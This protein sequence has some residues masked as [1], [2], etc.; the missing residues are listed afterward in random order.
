[1][2]HSGRSK[3]RWSTSTPSHKSNDFNPLYITKTQTNP[4][5]EKLLGWSTYTS[6]DLKPSHCLLSR[7][8]N[9]TYDFATLH[10]SRNKHHNILFQCRVVWINYLASITGMAVNIQGSEQCHQFLFISTPVITRLRRLVSLSIP[11]IRTAT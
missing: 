2:L 8:F 4:A 11:P 10:G 6:S 7:T 9:R 5:T 1:M 3:V